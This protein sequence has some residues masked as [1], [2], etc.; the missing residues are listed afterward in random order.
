MRDQ[1]IATTLNLPTQLT[2]AFSRFTPSMNAN[3]TT[4]WYTFF[5]L[6]GFQ[7]GAKRHQKPQQ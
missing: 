4:G 5:I 2:L 6:F 3:R 1:E 7:I